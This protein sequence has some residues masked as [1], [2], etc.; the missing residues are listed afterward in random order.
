[1]RVDEFV[2][3]SLQ[4]IVEGVCRAQRAV[5]SNGGQINP[6]RGP[7]LRQF[8]DVEFD[9]AVT[10]EEATKTGGELGVSMWA[11]KAGTGGASENR[12]QA[13]NRLRF[14]VPIDLPLHRETIGRKT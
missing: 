1:M 10:V 14:K 6:D 13:V 5:E 8:Q 3:T 12:N 4:Q 7:G 11:I 9:L 2:A